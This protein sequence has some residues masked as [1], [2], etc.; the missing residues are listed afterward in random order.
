MHEIN[1]LKYELQRIKA[2]DGMLIESLNNRVKEL[3]LELDELRQIAESTQLVCTSA[4]Q[5]TNLLSSDVRVQSTSAS[6][7]FTVCS[8]NVRAQCGSTLH[9]RCVRVH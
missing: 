2:E 1:E 9:H 7:V 6:R 8:Y 5:S 4:V 3:E